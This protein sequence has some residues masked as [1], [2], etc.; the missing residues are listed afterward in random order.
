[1][2][3]LLLGALGGH[4]SDRAVERGRGRL[5]IVLVGSCW[6]RSAGVS[7]PRPRSSH[8]VVSAMVVLYS[9]LN[10]QRSPFHA[11]WRIGA[12]TLSVAGER[13]R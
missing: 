2:L 13:R 5:N 9:G 6:R 3:L 8:G 10:V 11:L 1:M 7:R 4:V 12:V